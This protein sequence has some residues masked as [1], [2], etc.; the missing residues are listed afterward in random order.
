MTA[1]QIAMR[2]ITEDCARNNTRNYLYCEDAI[3]AYLG[4]KK[5]D[6]RIFNGE[7]LNK[8]NN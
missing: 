8:R 7:H 5:P 4:I 3:L 1:K 6:F 2:D